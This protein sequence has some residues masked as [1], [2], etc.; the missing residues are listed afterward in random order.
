LE[1]VKKTNATPFAFYTQGD[2]TI[3]LRV[4]EPSAAKE[5]FANV[6]LNFPHGKVCP[7]S[8]V[9]SLDVSAVI[10][11]ANNLMPGQPLNI[12]PKDLVMAKLKVFFIGIGL[13]APVGH[14]LMYAATPS[15]GV[16]SLMVYPP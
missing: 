16:P 15:N 1:L 5:V 10:G 9:P 4:S 3:A 13:P 6:S 11:F 2:V 14:T 8:T 7:T 12:V